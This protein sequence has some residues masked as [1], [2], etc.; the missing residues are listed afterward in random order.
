MRLHLLNTAPSAACGHVSRWGSGV[1]TSS[2]IAFRLTSL[3]PL[4]EGGTPLRGGFLT[5]LVVFTVLLAATVLLLFVC[6]TRSSSLL[7][8]IMYPLFAIKIVNNI[9]H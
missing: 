8:F 2:R 1:T 5:F 4:G 7:P 6:S 3:S 9:M